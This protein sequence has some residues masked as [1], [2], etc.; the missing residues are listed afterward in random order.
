MTPA[1]TV[2]IG[3]DARD[4]IIK[5]ADT[6]ADAVK[7]T[8]GPHGL[9]G[10]YV[11]GGTKITN[12]GVSIAKEIALEDEIEQLGVV[13]LRE[14]SEK[15][16]D[17]AGDG[18]TTAITL[19]QAILRSLKPYL[20]KKG[21]YDSRKSLAELRKLVKKETEDII[22]ILVDSAVPIETEQQLIDAA[23]VSVEDEVLAEM[24]G[25]AQFK[26]GKNGVVIAEEHAKPVD[27]VEHVKGIRM[28]NGFGTSLIIND[29]EKQRLVES[30][31]PVILTNHD[32]NSLKDLEQII[33]QI[34]KS[35]GTKLAIVARSFSN[36]TIQ[37]CM[38][39]HEVGY[40]IYPINAPYVDQTQVMKDM[41]AVLGGSFINKEEKDL[42]SVQM[43]DLGFATRI[44]AE[45]FSAIFTG[46][47]D[48][49]VSARV[50]EL[51]K[52]LEGSPSAFERTMIESRLAQLQNGFA[53]VKVGS[54][55]DQERKYKK[56]K[57]DD[58]VNAVR[59]AYQ[60]GVVRGGGYAL[61]SIGLE[62]P[63][64]SILREAIQAPYNQIQDNAGE[65]FEIPEWVYDPVKVVR[66]ALEKAS[67]VAMTLAT[68]GVAIAQP[69]PKARY[70]QEVDKQDDG[71]NL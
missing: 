45:R 65:E 12:D 46:K 5:G 51:E 55:S 13:A 30:D 10:I 28:D 8:L 24:I 70:V 31:I 29:Q 48:V 18:T 57:V 44:V 11:K 66:I 19:A 25:K 61:K 2:K 53:I 6:L 71:E 36:E 33:S 56:D 7:L 42:D 54:T 64:D 34:R 50:A 20:L 26:V 21:Q 41:A 3:V 39:N 62:M 16:N 58:A 27:I 43:S 14:A 9:N 38:K 15:T 40:M 35:G 69:R 52:M 59:A 32:L 37:L 4:S 49:D 63:E 17:E 67:S 47:D 1:R 60:E 22:K 68:T 23:R